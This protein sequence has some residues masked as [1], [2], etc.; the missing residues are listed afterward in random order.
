M[1]KIHHI[2][3]PK[4]N[5]PPASIVW[6]IKAKKVPALKKDLRVGTW[7]LF[8]LYLLMLK[9][10]STF[11]MNENLFFKFAMNKNLF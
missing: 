2:S 6:N 4:I 3:P 7:F 10:F 8:R 5:F 11:C 1:V 9:L